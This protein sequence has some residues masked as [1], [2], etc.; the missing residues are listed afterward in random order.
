MVLGIQPATP[1]FSVADV[2][3]SPNLLEEADGT[4]VTPK[5][6]LR[7]RWKASAPAETIVSSTRCIHLCV[8]APAGIKVVL[9]VQGTL[10]PEVFRF[11]GTFEG[12]I[13]MRENVAS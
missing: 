12:H 3:P 5:G 1:G 9:D 13:Q 8:E 10:K 11:E 7:V 4:V 2:R 6:P